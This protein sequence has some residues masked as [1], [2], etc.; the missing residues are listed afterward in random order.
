MKILVKSIPQA[1]EIKVDKTEG[2]I[3]EDGDEEP[4][5]ILKEIT[6]VGKSCM[7]VDATTISI[8]KA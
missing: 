6:D 1:E 8:V 3:I 2:S 7:L 5:P 4:A